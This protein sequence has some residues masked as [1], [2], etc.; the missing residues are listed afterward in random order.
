MHY[1]LSLFLTA[2]G[3]LAT[4]A[5][6]TLEVRVDNIRQAK[7]QVR[8]AIFT[9]P[10]NFLDYQN[11]VYLASISLRATQSA[12][13]FELPPLAPGQYAIATYHD[14]NNNDQLDT[15]LFGIPTE[16]YAFSREP[17][18]KW[19]EPRWN[20]VA[21]EYRPEQTKLQLRLKTWSER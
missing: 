17:D 18:S 10:A 13:V 19:R 15:N 11:A 21:F 5:P 14:R 8:I 1:L 20:E 12:V 3:Y 4:E 6:S 2:F 7:G 16:P 9:E